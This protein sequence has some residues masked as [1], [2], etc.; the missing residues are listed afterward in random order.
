MMSNSSQSALGRITRGSHIT[1]YSLMFFIAYDFKGQVPVFAGLV[2]VVS[3]SSCR[4]SAILKYFSPL[5]RKDGC[6]SSG[7]KTNS[8]HRKGTPSL[9]TTHPNSYYKSPDNCKI[10]APWREKTSLWWFANNTGPDQPVHSRSLIS[11][12]VICV[13]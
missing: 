4:T 5:Y 1:Y 11:A 8:L 2:K 7:P 3:H 12:F 9:K 10:Y 6:R 13:L